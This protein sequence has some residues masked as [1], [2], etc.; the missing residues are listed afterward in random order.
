MAYQICK[1]CSKMFSKNGKLYCKDCIEKAEKEND[2]I[3]DYVRQYPNST[4]LDIITET[5]VTLKSINALVEDGYVSYGDNKLKSLNSDDLSKITDKL[6]DKK[7][8]F[9]IRLEL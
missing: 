5:G 8:Q 6:I 1:R 3:I 7:G 4:I 9:H 2:L